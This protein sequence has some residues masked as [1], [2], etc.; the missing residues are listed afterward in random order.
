MK[1]VMTI[2]FLFTWISASYAQT[3]K[4]CY[5]TVYRISDELPELI[6]SQEKIASFI[7]NE[8]QLPDSLLK[9]SEALLIEY[10]V[11]CNGDAVRFR[12]IQTAESDGTLIVNHFK[13]L[14]KPITEILGRELKYKPAKKGGN[15]VDFLKIFSM[16]FDKGEMSIGQL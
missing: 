8:I 2:L 4:P 15:T 1:F 9:Y 6:S 14:V 5:A 7:G 3:K 13:P 16:R 12:V 11:N 10:V